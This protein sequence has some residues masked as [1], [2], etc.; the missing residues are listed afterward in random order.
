MDLKNYR[1]G[2]LV[3]VSYF[4]SE[5][6]FKEN[7]QDTYINY[8]W[9]TGYIASIEPENMDYTY[10]IELLKNNEIHAFNIEEWQRVEPIENTKKRLLELGF[11]PS[12]DF[13]VLL[14]INN[15]TSILYNYHLKTCNLLFLEGEI[16]LSHIKYI[17][18]IQN[19]YHA[20]TGKDI[21]IKQK[22]IS[23]I[24]NPLNQQDFSKP[25]E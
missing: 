6:D 18:Q 7:I 1:I 17:H 12:D 19:L 4:K 9:Y 2:N 15:T 21:H 23:I 13:E 5:K 16:E 25:L 8:E 20:L 22:N 3:K 14:E 10:R 11:L 24:P